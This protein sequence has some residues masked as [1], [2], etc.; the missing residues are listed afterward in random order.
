MITPD[1]PALLCVG[2]FPTG[3]G[4]TYGQG[5]RKKVALNGE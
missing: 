4:L 5:Q 3:S 2:S 1:A